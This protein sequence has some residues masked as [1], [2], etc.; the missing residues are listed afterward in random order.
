MICLTVDDRLYHVEFRHVRKDGAHPAL[1]RR[2][3]IHAIT[4][5]VIIATKAGEPLGLEPSEILFTAIGN[6]I[7]ALDDAFSRRKGRLL[8]FYKAVTHCG[9]LRDVRE[10]LLAAYLNHDPDPCVEIRPALT[11]PEKAVLWQKGW[12]RRK[13]RELARTA[14]SAS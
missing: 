10:A 4:T 14:R 2:A 7:C 6:A 3:P 13:Q 5:C 11:Q 8:S 9:A 1:G 12:E